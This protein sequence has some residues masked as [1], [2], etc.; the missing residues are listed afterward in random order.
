M[1]EWDRRF[2]EA[3]DYAVWHGFATGWPNFHQAD[4]GDGLVY[5]TFR[6]YSPRV[7]GCCHRSAVTLTWPRADMTT[8]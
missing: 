1:G 7:D 8:R 4:Y 3:H 2:R 6:S 5:G